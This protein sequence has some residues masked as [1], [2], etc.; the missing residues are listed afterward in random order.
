MNAGKPAAGNLKRRAA[1][2]RD[3]DDSGPH[4]GE[5]FDDPSHGSLLYRS[6]PGEHR[7]KFLSGQ[8]TG[9]QPHGSTAVPD[10][11][12]LL[13]PG[14]T[15]QAFSVNEHFAFVIFNRD[16]HLLKAGDGGQAIRALQEI[17]DSSSAF[18]QRSEHDGAV[19]D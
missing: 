8:D 1:V 16:P 4:L 9:Q 2:A 6:I 10:I 5:R 17:S 11:Q 19:G 14:Q 18:R 15:V 12:R 13:R 3:T 7:L